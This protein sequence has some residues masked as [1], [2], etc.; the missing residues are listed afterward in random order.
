ME[1][2]GS[3]YLYALATISV[4]FVGFSAL[5]LV[6]RQT[7]GGATTRYDGYF[8]MAF[9]QVGFIVAGG[10]LL[11]PL[12]ALF[13]LPEAAIW[14]A[15]SAV[16]ACLILLFVATVPSR[17]RAAVG[18]AAPLFVKLLLFLQSLMAVYLLTNAAGLRPA[19]GVAD[20]ASVMAGML[21]T[22]GIAYLLALDRALREPLP[23]RN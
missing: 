1:M 8:I 21:F 15:S 19:S 2:A 14:R 5:L 7:V 22:S 11:P 13:E 20:Y 16:A 4:T 9:M 10:S 12:L 6:F 23:P 3:S 17:R 18:A